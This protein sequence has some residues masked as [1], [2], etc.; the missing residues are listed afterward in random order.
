MGTKNGQWYTV[1]CAGNGVT[2]DKIELRTTQSTYLSISGIEVWTGA[3][4]SSSSN[5]TCYSYKHILGCVSGENIKKYKSKTKDECA[6][7]CDE[8]S[9][10]LGFEYFVKSGASK[11]NKGYGPGACIASSSTNIKGCDYK[12]HQM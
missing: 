6:K 12:Y 7:I 2:G 8:T 9:G 5:K 10:C 1:T 11:T 3:P 4:G